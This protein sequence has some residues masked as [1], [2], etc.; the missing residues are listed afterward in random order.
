MQA[1]IGVL[2]LCIISATVSCAIYSIQN[3]DRF[4]IDS[5]IKAFAFYIMM[6]YT[7]LSLFKTVMG[8]GMLRL[9]DTF[10]DVSWKTYLHYSFPLII[11]GIIAPLVI[12]K[13]LREKTSDFVN[14][15]ISVIVG[16]YSVVYLILGRINNLL[17]V[18]ISFIGIILALIIVFCNKEEVQY[19]TRQNIK[20]RL[21]LAVPVMLFWTITMVLFLPNELY[22]SNIN[23]MTILYRIFIRTLLLGALGYFA[24]YTI[25]L[26]YFLT[27]KQFG[28]VCAVIFG[29][30][31]AGY[32]QGVVLNGK[33]N[34]MDGNRQSWPVMTMVVNAVIWLL[35]IGIVVCLRYLIKKNV[36]KVYS[37]ICI[38]LSLIQLF[39]WGYLRFTT[40]IVDADKDFEITTDGRFELNPDHNVIVFVLDW[41]DVQIMNRV[42]EED[43]EFL[44]PL[45]DFTWYKNMTSLYSYTTMSLPYLLSNVEWQYDMNVKEYR[46]YVFQGD[47]LLKDIADRNYDVRV[48]TNKSFVSE[49]V[50]DIVNNYSD[51]TVF[52]WD[53]YGILEQMIKCSKYKSYPFALKSGYWYTG[54]QLSG[55]LRDAHIHNEANDAPFYEEL[56]S[57]GVHVENRGN[58]AGAYRF[59]HLLGA[60][61]PFEPDMVSQGKWSMNIVYEY[62]RQLKDA[63]M[64][65]EATIIITAD[66]GHNYLNEDYE[67]ELLMYNL[68]KAASPIL[69]VKKSYQT[70]EDMKISMAPVSHEQ[71]AA[72]IM[73]AIDKDAAG[74]GETFDDV[75]EDR[76]CERY[77]I[78]RRRDDVPYTKFA[79]NGYAGDWN[80]W[81]IVEKD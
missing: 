16:I 34:V 9:T 21:A 60:H 41:Y 76:Q 12:K 74:Y 11:I 5:L 27:E 30:T 46:E 40:E 17:S 31:F 36:D 61:P 72:T 22:F 77:L 4:N 55:E 58:Y 33:M 8:Y 49:T 35:I 70:N 52:G 79:I 20:A 51:I 38:Y 18:C 23:D 81:N 59:Y 44:E 15:T 10:D 66:H 28:F 53:T 45:K 24:V 7:I 75:E 64:Y 2:V 48:F 73:E 32:L 80:N 47:S 19:C 65:D 29:L 3:R 69:F 63:G 13:L 67:D 37:M 62:I 1:Y 42:L 68:E 78:F 71:M 14:L 54:G 56:M 25:L 6:F 50:T 26:V 39:A 57:D 43:S